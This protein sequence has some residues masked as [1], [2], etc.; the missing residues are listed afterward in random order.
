M[1]VIGMSFEL[2]SYEFF[3]INE[4]LISQHLYNANYSKIISLISVS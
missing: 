3:S 2:E 4:D 1:F